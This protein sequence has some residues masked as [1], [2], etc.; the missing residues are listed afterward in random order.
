ML[1]VALVAVAGLLVA[2][3]FACVPPPNAPP[4]LGVAAARVRLNAVPT[5]SSDGKPFLS[6]VQLLSSQLGYLRCG[7]FVLE[8]ESL[9]RG[10]EVLY[11]RLE[12]RTG[13]LRCG[14][15]GAQ[16]RDEV[17]WGLL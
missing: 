5:C 9:D 4:T 12:G 11:L 6:H 13:F 15:I 14:E 8:F 10:G 1:R 3:S 16:A 17:V 7:G 2:I